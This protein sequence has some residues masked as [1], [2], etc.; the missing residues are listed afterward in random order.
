MNSFSLL[1]PDRI[2][3]AIARS[4]ID[5]IVLSRRGL[6]CEVL[7]GF[8]LGLLV[9]NL[10][11]TDP[12]PPLWLV[13]KLGGYDDSQRH[14]IMIF[15]AFRT[16]ETSMV[17]WVHTEPCSFGISEAKYRSECHRNWFGRKVF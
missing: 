2:P 10:G 6:C 7:L 11:G 8:F 9:E 5:R 15:A 14:T 16:E 17:F 12:V 4:N 1:H 13:S 3:D